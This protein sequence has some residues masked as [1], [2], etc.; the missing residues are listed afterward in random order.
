MRP[1]RRPHPLLSGQELPGIPVAAE[2]ICCLTEAAEFRRVLLERIAGATRR[3]YLVA[4][5][6]QDDEAGREIMDALH[7]AVEA[8][9][10]L[11][12]RVLVDWHRAQRGL[13]G[14]GKSAGNA[15]MYQ[16]Y[17][18]RF[19]QAIQ[20]LGVPV[21]N[22]ELFGVLHL[23]GFIIDDAVL[24]SGASLNEIYL[25][26]H[27]RY[28][29]DRYHVIESPALAAC[30]VDYLHR[31]F[32][33]SPAVCSLNQPVIPRRQ[34]GAVRAFRRH[35]RTERYDFQA[36]APDHGQVVLTPLSGFG[37]ADN[38]L[39]DALL[40]L[41]KSTQRALV[42]YTPYFNLPQPIAKALARLL[43]Q[44]RS[45]TIVVGDKVANDFYIPPTE[46]FKT[47]GL[48]P[49]LYESNLRRFALKH[50]E[51]IR[52]GRLN[53]H[54]WRHADNSFHLKGLFIDDRVA[55]L[56]GN[57]LNP[58]AWTLDLENGLIIQDPEGLL[59]SMHA[60]ERAAILAHAPRLESYRD[61]E[62]PHHYPLPVQKA[63]KRMNRIRLDR[64]VNR[65][66]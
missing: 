13:I 24:Y 22:R 45:V 36:S 39:N 19:G 1:G 42:L 37:R 43:E 14:K 40:A 50:R 3:I 29:L 27:T 48:L 34:S 64:L 47:I 25:A 10:G 11:D 53:V 54:L 32:L 60:A 33:D 61:L 62:T 16:N 9:P 55:V 6:L 7:A 31:V 35:L 51:A 2:R 44:G 20:V 63:L 23:K 8:R 59:A 57:N 28:R 17:A 30:M 52:D 5:Y 18:A 21:Q 38:P 58:R 56:T 41:V 15:A 12:V 46:P 65:L 26:T 49:Y 66:L 4:L